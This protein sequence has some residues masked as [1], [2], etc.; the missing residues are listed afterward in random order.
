[1]SKAESKQVVKNNSFMSIQEALK[2]TTAH[3]NNS[4]FDDIFSQLLKP[5]SEVKYM[6]ETL[7]KSQKDNESL[8]SEQPMKGEAEGSAPRPQLTKGASSAKKQRNYEE[9]P[10][11]APK[12]SSKPTGPS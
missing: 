9:H 1:M 10:G 8:V 5:L 4:D 7:D 11:M 3:N 6:S 12:T 2:K